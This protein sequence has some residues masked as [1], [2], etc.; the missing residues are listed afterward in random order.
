MDF[1]LV[2]HSCRQFSSEV[3]KCEFSANFK[4]KVLADISNAWYLLKFHSEQQ[5]LLLFTGSPVRF[6][7]SE[8][9]VQVRFATN[10]LR[11]SFATLSP[12]FKIFWYSVAFLDF[13]MQIYYQQSSWWDGFVSVLGVSRHQIRAVAKFRNSNTKHYVKA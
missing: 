4:R 9:G 13:S 10:S 1:Y 8:L 6:L 7:F 2:H 5:I 11:G 3:F 12:K